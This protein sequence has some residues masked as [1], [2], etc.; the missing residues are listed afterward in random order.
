[1]K[2]LKGH[3]SIVMGVL[4]LAIIVVL[5]I[6]AWR[7]LQNHPISQSNRL[8]TKAET[9]YTSRQFVE[10]YGEYKR[11]V[12]SLGNTEPEVGINYANA[13]YLSS[14]M[15]ATGNRKAGEPLTQVDSALQQVFTLSQEQYMHL[16]SSADAGIASTA[17][18]QLGYSNV[19]GKNLFDE[20]G[21]DSVLFQALDYFKEALRKNPENDSA[22]HNYELIKKVIDFPE[23]IMAEAQAL[24]A[25]KKYRQAAALL[26]SGMRRDPR[27]RKKKDFMERLRTV[28]TIDSLNS[29][30]L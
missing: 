29:R 23:A 6:P 21:G 24:I 5:A 2:V 9:A 13:A 27:L 25:Q 22:R 14:Q 3:L 8:K 30:S 17:A 1:M 16:L 10:A 15:L 26:E 12:D 4:L 7:L 28:I 18:N 19:K 11:L 20:S